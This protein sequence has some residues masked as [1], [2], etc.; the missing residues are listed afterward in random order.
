M[1]A[2]EVR[3]RGMAARRVVV[4]GREAMYMPSER[5]ARERVV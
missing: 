1:D 4:N 5:E 2:E 3:E